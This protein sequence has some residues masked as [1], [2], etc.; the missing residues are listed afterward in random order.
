MGCGSWSSGKLCVLL[1]QALCTHTN[2]L[3]ADAAAVSA[4]SCLR[5]PA[6]LRPTCTAW[7]VWRRGS[8]CAELLFLCPSRARCCLPN[9]PQ[10]DRNKCNMLLC[11]PD[12]AVC[13]Q[14][15]PPGQCEGS[16]RRSRARHLLHRHITQH[17]PGGSL[18]GRQVRLKRE[19]VLDCMCLEGLGQNGLA[20]C[21]ALEA[22]QRQQLC[23]MWSVRWVS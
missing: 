14:P 20:V 5:H 1:Q 13:V 17:I 9:C 6:S 15:A 22:V 12:A 21:A 18:Q 4:T 8:P 7:Q 19:L 11:L 2:A 16:S 23:A 10:Q 3:T